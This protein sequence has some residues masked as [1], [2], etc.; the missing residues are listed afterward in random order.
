LY[1][2]YNVQSIQAK[3]V[4]IAEFLLRYLSISNAPPRASIFKRLWSPGID[5]KGSIPPAY[6]AGRYNPIP[7]RFLAPI[8]CL[9][10]PALDSLFKT[11]RKWI[12][13][14]YKMAGLVKWQK[15][16]LH[17]TLDHFFSQWLC[18]YLSH[19]HTLIFSH[20]APHLLDTT[21]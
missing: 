18:F 5:S 12:C 9:K 15:E 17:A 7:T 10:I 1:I 6:V 2:L 21:V 4:T 8:D 16:N 3:T 11:N 19:I 20:S 13:V 14:E